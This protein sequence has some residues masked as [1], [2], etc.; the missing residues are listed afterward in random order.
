MLS[1]KTKSDPKSTKR[2]I[3]YAAERLFGKFNYDGTSIKDISREAGVNSALIS[4]YF[5]SKKGLYCDVLQDNFTKF[6]NT[7]DETSF[8]GLSPV[9]ALRKFM[10]DQIHLQLNNPSGVRIIYRELMEPS[11]FGEPLMREHVKVIREKLI[12][13]VTAGQE[14]GTIRK[15]PDAKTAT[16]TLISIL[17]FFLLTK[18]FLHP[19]E[20][21][22]SDEYTHIYKI[23]DEYL[24][25]LLTGKKVSA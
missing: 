23:Y 9:S 24:Q 4:Y 8:A 25:S 12:S 16:F 21:E 13:L 6:L 14:N 15:R 1:T 7:L 10:E 3:L 5:G 22:K 19:L 11:E 2:K 18:D 20:E 17:G